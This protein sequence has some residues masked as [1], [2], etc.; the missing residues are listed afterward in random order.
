MPASPSARGS[1]EKQGAAASLLNGLAVLEAFSQTGRRLLS[2]T[3]VA[4]IVGL[5]KSTVS[6]MLGGLVEAGYLQRDELTGRFGLGLGLIGLAGPLLAELDVRRA[7]LPHLV[8]MTER[9]GETS[10]VALWNGAE[11]VVVEQVSSP[12]FVKHSATIGTRYR[13]VESSSV[14]LVLAEKGRAEVHEMLDLGEIDTSSYSG[15]DDPVHSRLAQVRAQGYAVNDGET[16]PDEYS[17]S[18]PIRDYH[19]ALVACITA[20]APRSRVQREGSGEELVAATRLAAVRVG[21]RL[22]AP[23]RRGDD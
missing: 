1:T 7:A 18:A 6:R 17:V 3:E 8:S 10:V 11:V 20:S 4:E 5:H 15:V 12:H 14:Q 23:R 21:E 2:V 16:N 9:T 19:G 13:R 22:G